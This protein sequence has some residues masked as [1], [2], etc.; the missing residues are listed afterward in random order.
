MVM[1]GDFKSCET[2]HL[3]SLEN[4]NPMKVYKEI[5]KELEKYDKNSREEGE[6]LSEKK[7]III[8]TKT[9]VVEDRKF[10]DKKVK[11]FS[12]LEKQVFILS[13]Y[14]DKSIKILQDALVKILQKKV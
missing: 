2:P 4:E 12:T 7:E 8:L 9:D 13:L 5:R 10:I 6:K 1:T 14:D 3:I 11:E